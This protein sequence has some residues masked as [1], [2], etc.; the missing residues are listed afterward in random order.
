M[1]TAIAGDASF[2]NGFGIFIS[3]ALAA[4]GYVPLSIA[5]QVLIGI[6]VLLLWTCLNFFRID[7]V[8]WLNSVAAVIHLGTIVLIFI[9]LL[10]LAREHLSSPKTVFTEYYDVT[11]F[12][13][14]LYSCLLSLVV[15]MWAFAG[16]EGSSHMAEETTHGDKAAS[17]GMIWTVVASGI[18]GI[19]FIIM[20]LFLTTNISAVVNGTNIVNTGNT[21]VNIIVTAFGELWG[22]LVAWLIVVNF[23]FTGM[24]SVTVTG[25]LTYSLARDE[26]L[27]W[28]DIL[29]YVDPY[30][31]SPICSIVFPAIIGVV[32]NMLPFTTE[33][34]MA[35]FS[36]VGL[37]TIGYQVSYGIPIMLK[38]LYNP[39]DFPLTTMSLGD[40]SHP[41]GILSCTWLLASSFLFFIPMSA[42][43]TLSNMNWLCVVA[44][45]TIVIGW[46]NWIVNARY[47]FK[48]P[49]RSS[50]THTDESTGLLKEP[51]SD[52][53]S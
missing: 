40:W 42:P 21:V 23:F 36:I 35:F 33:G 3:A 28:S 25:R 16:Y 1:L 7:Q 2:A 45:I 20:L 48:G 27:P 18:L 29:T 49:K 50:A 37:S 47:T 22:S 14:I 5:Y 34:A 32:L 39:P 30:F 10:V 11:G 41:L 8:G 44:A 17:T 38:V 4:S 6:G 46:L 26:A 53:E 43:V 31:K 13:S 19:S 24:A 51:L 52:F 9:L 12:G 15:G